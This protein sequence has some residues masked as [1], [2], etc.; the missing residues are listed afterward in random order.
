M[1]NYQLVAKASSF[2]E[3]NTELAA[4][5]GQ[6]YSGD[7]VR[8]ILELNEPLAPAFNLAGA[9]LIFSQVMPEGLILDDVHGEGWSTVIIEAHATSP[10]LAAIGVWLAANWVW[11]TLGAIGIAVALGVLI[12]SVSFL[13]LSV[14]SPETISKTAMWVAIGVGGLAV[15]GL[16]FY[17]SQ[18]KRPSLSRA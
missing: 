18:K 10:P 7:K 5:G 13:V 1:N 14:R 11:V 2:D 12:Y 4:T 17:A 15:I 8:M 6:L 3:L 9:E 16:I